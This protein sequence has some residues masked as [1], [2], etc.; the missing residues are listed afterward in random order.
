VLFPSESRTRALG[1]PTWRARRC[2]NAFAPGAG[3]CGCALSDSP[4]VG[5]DVGVA[6]QDGTPVVDTDFV[7][8]VLVEGRVFSRFIDGSNRLSLFADLDNTG[9]GVS[10]PLLPRAFR[11]SVRH[12]YDVDV[13]GEVEQLTMG[14]RA[15]SLDRLR[16]LRVGLALSAPAADGVATTPSFL[17]A[18]VPLQPGKRVVV[19]EGNGV[20]RAT[21]VFQ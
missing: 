11:F 20:L 14:P 4:R 19:V 3:L 15:A 2:V 6:A 1:G 16:L 21:G 10:T 13:D 9:E 17:G 5:V 18:A 8:G 12:G 7:G